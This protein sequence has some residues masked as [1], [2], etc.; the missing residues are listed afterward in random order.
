MVGARR[1]RSMHIVLFGRFGIGDVD[2]NATASIVASVLRERCRDGS[3]T[4]VAFEP[5]PFRDVDAILVDANDERAVRTAITGADLV[6]VAGTPWDAAGDLDLDD[7]FR[8]PASTP[9]TIAARALLRAA[10]AGIPAA[11]FAIG[12]APAT[13][14]ARLLGFLASLAAHVSVRDGESAVA[15]R[16]AGFVGALAVTA[17]P[18]FS[19]VPA[20]ALVPPPRRRALRVGIAP[21]ATGD[22]SALRAV[23]AALATLAA[24]RPLDV[25][26]PP[27]LDAAALGLD[28]SD[29]S[30]VDFGSAAATARLLG[31]CD[32]V[33]TTSTQGAVLAAVAE[34]PAVTVGANP[35]LRSH[36]KILGCADLALDPA[37]CGV[38]AIVRVIERAVDGRA[39]LATHLA[40]RVAVARTALDGDLEALLSL[41]RHEGAT[42]EA[43]RIAALERVSQ[44]LRSRLEQREESWRTLATFLGRDVEIIAPS[45]SGVTQR[46]HDVDVLRRRAEA[47]EAEIAAIKR[48]RGWRLLHGYGILKH[49]YL[50]PLARRLGLRAGPDAPAPEVVDEPA[51][52]PPAPG[53]FDVVCFPIIDW[54]FRF[55]RPQQLMTRFAAAGHRVF[56]VEP[57]F[58]PPG[59]PPVV[60]MKGPNLHHVRLAGRHR[61]VWTEALDDEARDELLASLN[62][63]RIDWDLGA[64]LTVVQLPFWWP[65][66]ARARERFAWPIF[67]D[68]M[69]D[70]TGFTTFTGATATDEDALFAQADLV[71]VSSPALAERARRHRDQVLL[72]RNACDFEH[73]ATAGTPR[74]RGARPVVGFYG[75]IAHWFD[76]DLVADLAERRPDWDFVLVGS[77]H[78]GDV[79]R[80]AR[81][82]NV[83]LPGEQP[84]ADLPAWLASFDVTILPFK[85]M[86]LTEAT[87]PVKAY[88]TLASGKP[89]VSVPLPEMRLLGDLVRFADTPEEFEREIVAA[90]DPADAAHADAR[91]AFA[92][93]HTWQTRY[94]LLATHL[95]SLFPRA[96]T[97]IVTYNN[98]ELNRACLEHLF[99]R[100]DWP[101]HETIVVDNASS[102]GT[103]EYLE[104]LAAERTDV[105]VIANDRNLGFAAACNQGLARASGAYLV[106]L[107][108]D[109]VVTRGWLSTLIRH[110]HRMPDVGLVGPV[111][112]E[113]GNEAKV[114]VGYAD[115]AAMPAWAARF[116]RE[117]A[118]RL[119]SMTM[120]AMFCV[121][122]R[123]T[124]FEE[125]GPLDERFEIGMFEDDDYARRMHQRGYRVVV[126]M[127]A[128]VHH[129]GGASFKRLDDARYREL[130]ERNRRAYE[131]KWGPWAPHQDD[132]ATPHVARLSDRLRKI[133]DDADVPAHDVVVF[134]PILREPAEHARRANHVAAALAAQGML[135]FVDGGWGTNDAR[136]GFHPLAPNLWRYQGPRGTLERLDTP[137]VWA[138]AYNALDAFRWI[139]GTILYDATDDPAIFPID[140]DVLRANHDRMLREADL[141]VCG[142]PASAREI[143]S[144]RPDVVHLAPPAVTTRAAAEPSDAAFGH[145]LA[146]LLRTRRAAGRR[147]A[148][149]IPTHA[150]RFVGHDFRR[151]TCNVCGHST[152]FYFT[153]AALYRESLTC[154]DCLTTS[155]YRS[156]ARGILRAIHELTGVDASSLADLARRPSP[157]RL[158]VYDTQ[159]A[160]R[161]E[162][163]AYPIPELLAACDW[164]D[165]HTSTLRPR[166]PLGK[167]L[168]DGR[169]NQS[170]ERLTF[171]DGS[172]DLVVTSDVMEH[173]RLDERAHREIR[174]VLAPGGIYLFTVP[175]DRARVE[176]LVRVGIVDPDDPSRD[177]FLLEPEYHGDANDEANA[178]LAYR[179]YGRDLD[180]T[181]ER[182][183]FG[184]EYTRADVPDAGILN[185]ELFYCRV[186]PSADTRAVTHP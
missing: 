134:P 71:T 29:L 117:H 4:L 89:I 10:A 122:M 164:I 112:N 65:I 83:R 69:D 40:A 64:T 148:D 6:V 38:D 121:A 68:C 99:A 93:A 163:N 113:I 35:A 115:L 61:D 12:V 97:V 50:F 1:S 72:L 87:N 74:P 96:S 120:L 165:V 7:L 5:S 62:R 18:A 111:T 154:G 57:R 140:P 136:V 84:Y 161:Y 48:S 59:E 162:R 3:L 2:E 100:T 150:D 32:V 86:P 166:E 24:R 102:D 103:H 55:Q 53:T 142:S 39:A 133:V 177:Q 67:Y 182:L 90:L 77:T 158:R 76:G 45:A 27:S 106:L 33:V 124:T 9:A 169:S 171:A 23:G 174:R 42:S 11:L 58:G 85:R 159:L 28:A 60:T 176:T 73:F 138:F 14:D 82:A 183:G 116:T 141:I 114:S 107:N 184:V 49:H 70:H 46:S 104:R 34:T 22:T 91:R 128:F 51:T 132:S 179:T 19:V 98:L 66:A 31:A 30:V 145:G 146:D 52:I 173:V 63:L 20:S 118:D 155:R 37:A 153:D 26:V 101:N 156:I 170:L 94:D 17:D 172:F 43:R 139:G 119:R 47:A 167:S 181:L 36:A 44:R 160:F 168:G 25:L 137:V 75:A 135:V 95:P 8:V 131:R 108:N 129:V 92:A 79:A 125:L 186:L 123:R 109:T 88:E 54:D 16:G 105:V 13:G 147:A 180:A 144:A 127:D 178:A 56:Y 80:L 152:A 175:H 185:T 149:R 81:L 78:T 21:P 15:L 151:G 130:F 157:R 143:A 110:L 41:A 126:A